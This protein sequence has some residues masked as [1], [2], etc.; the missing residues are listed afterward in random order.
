MTVGWLH[1]KTI[2]DAKK[3]L[4]QEQRSRSYHLPMREAMVC[5]DCEAVFKITER[6]PACS[7][8]VVAALGRWLNR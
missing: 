4:A 8:E 6:C 7:S 1:P 3:L 2:E 5:L